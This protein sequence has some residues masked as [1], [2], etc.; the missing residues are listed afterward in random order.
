MVAAALV[1]GISGQL[2]ITIGLQ[3]I[4]CHSGHEG[5]KSVRGERADCVI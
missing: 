5:H 4:S 1:L 2:I 3:T